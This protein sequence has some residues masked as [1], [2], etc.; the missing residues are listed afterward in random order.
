M[1]SSIASISCKA[2]LLTWTAYFPMYSLVSVKKSY[3]S[4]Y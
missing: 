1:P 2:T 4:S 3:V